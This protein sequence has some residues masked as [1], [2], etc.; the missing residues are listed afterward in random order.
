LERGAAALRKIG[1]KVVSCSLPAWVAEAFTLHDT[2]QGWEA[3]RAL[4]HETEHG[5]DQLSP[6]L[7]DYLQ[8]SLSIS[9]E[10]Y[11]ADQARATTARVAC[12]AWLAGID[13]LLTPSA[14]DEPP[15]GYGSTGVSTFNRAWTLLGTPCVGVPGCTGVNQRPMGLQL[16]APPGEDALCLAAGALLERALRNL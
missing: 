14:P 1:A 3:V 13:V 12:R 10:A 6:L 5:R 9:D 2:I 11:A 16:I 8:A 15:E 4:A 7:R